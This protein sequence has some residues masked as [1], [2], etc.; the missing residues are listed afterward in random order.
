MKMNCSAVRWLT[1]FVERL[2]ATAAHWLRIQDVLLPTTDVTFAQSSANIGSM[3]HVHCLE[4]STVTECS[5][6]GLG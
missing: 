5:G 1:K 4:T 6:T 3:L 2:A